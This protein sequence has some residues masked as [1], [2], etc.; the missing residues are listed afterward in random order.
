ML[1]LFTELSIKMNLQA[2]DFLF[3]HRDPTFDLAKFE[4]CPN[5]S[6]LLVDG[7]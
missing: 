5:K 1:I 6:S 7:G 3:F 4:L 2:D